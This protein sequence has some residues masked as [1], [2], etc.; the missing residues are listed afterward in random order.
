MLKLFK[1]NTCKPSKTPMVKGTKFTIDMGE[2]RVDPT[3]YKQMA[4]KHIYLINTRLLH[5]Q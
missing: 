1:V 2:S 5:L 4:R 3:L